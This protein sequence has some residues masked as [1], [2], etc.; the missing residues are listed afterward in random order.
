MDKCEIKRS[1]DDSRVYVAV[2]AKSYRIFEKNRKLNTVI[3]N[4]V[5]L[6]KYLYIYY[7]TLQS[8]VRNRLS[9]TILGCKKTT[10]LGS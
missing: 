7:H 1:V 10:S 4:D 3:V 5:Q 9:K 6:Y 2:F 8:I